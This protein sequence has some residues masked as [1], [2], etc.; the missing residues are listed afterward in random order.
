MSI[1][2][3]ISNCTFKIYKDSNMNGRLDEDDEYVDNLEETEKGIYKKQNLEYGKYFISE[4]KAEDGYVISKETEFDIVE[5]GITINIELIDKI[6][7][8]LKVNIGGEEIEGATI[9][10]LDKNNKVIDEWIS[11]KEPHKIKNLVEGEKYTLHEEVAVD[12]YVK[13]TDIEFEVSYEK[14]NQHLELIDKVVEIVKTD[15]VTGDEIEGAELQVIDEDG[16]IIDEWI[17][18]KEN[19]KIIRLDNF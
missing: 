1:D 15:L 12:G 13:S 9:Q 4:T 10:V 14:E 7:D 18:S 5:D 17:S 8:M 16:N 3:A 6:V 11:E 19:H 2:I